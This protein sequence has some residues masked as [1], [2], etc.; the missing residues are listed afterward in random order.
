MSNNE[1]FDTYDLEIEGELDNNNN[2][3]NVDDTNSNISRN[4]ESSSTNYFIFNKLQPSTVWTYYDIS[5]SG[6]PICKKCNNTFSVKSSVTTLRRHLTSHTITAPKKRQMTIDEFRNDPHSTNDQLHRD[7]AVIKWIVCDLQ[8]FS[9]VECKEWHE[10]INGFDRRYSFH[11][12]HTIKNLILAQYKE[13]KK[14]IKLIINHIH[15]KISLTSD[16]WTANNNSAF[17]SLTI[18]YV[19]K[20]WKLQS[21]LLDIIPFSLSVRHTGINITRAIMEA[22]EEYNLGTKT[23]ALTT[24]NAS[25][26]VLCGRLLMDELDNT[27]NNLSFSHYRCA[28]HVLNLAVQEG[29]QLIGEA[30]E[31]VRSLVTYLR[32]SL[33]MLNSLQILCEMKR[34]NYLAPELDCKTRW[35][36]CY[37]MLKKFV[38]LLP[39]L[40][41]LRIDNTRVNELY[42]TEIEIKNI[43]VC[44]FIE[45]FVETR[46]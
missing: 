34:I 42:P 38:H 46:I 29:L 31:K 6:N 1:F 19:D 20:N 14:E 33:P 7:N 32:S 2:V 3:I 5:S 41:L 44:K 28:A 18:H 9:V 10:M 39:A 15:G 26:M 45:K 13:K 17:L 43:L 11:N 16:M 36:T 22:L 8:S 23:L 37:Y 4:S 12:R 24:D 21:F 35:N 30:V 25:T 40:N 27:F